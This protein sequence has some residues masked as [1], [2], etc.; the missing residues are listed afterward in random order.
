[1]TQH[2]ADLAMA[3]GTKLAVKP[4]V[5]SNDMEKAVKSAEKAAKKAA[6]EVEEIVEAA[7]EAE[8]ETKDAE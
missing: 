8:V 3:R 6:K 7:I 4:A 5:I 1:M 2:P